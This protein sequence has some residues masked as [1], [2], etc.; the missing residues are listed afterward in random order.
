MAR[1][2]RSD[3]LMKSWLQKARV[4]MA[5]KGVLNRKHKQR[6]LL[7]APAAIMILK[8]LLSRRKNHPKAFLRIAAYVTALSLPEQNIALTAAVPFL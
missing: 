3:P 5:W 2:D 1:K 6:L 7:R 8:G 4:K